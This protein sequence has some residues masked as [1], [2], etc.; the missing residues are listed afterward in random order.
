MRCP[1]A[2]ALEFTWLERCFCTDHEI[3]HNAGKLVFLGMSA[4]IRGLWRIGVEKLKLHNG[5]RVAIIGGGPA[6]AFFA[7][8]ALKLARQKGLQITVTIFDGKNFMR[9]GP[10]GCNMCAGVISETLL[11]RLDAQ[12]IRL[13]E[14]RVQRRIDGYSV[15]TADQSLLLTHP[16]GRL[17]AISTVYRGSGP[18]FSPQSTDVS[19]DDFLLNHA[20]SDGARVVEEVVRDIVLSS[21]A[22]QP[23]RLLCGGPDAQVA[24]EADLLVGAFGLNTTI[25]EKVVA[26]GFGYRPPRYVR[27]FQ[28][29]L[30]MKQDHIR[31]CLGNNIYAFSLGLGRI[32][33]AAITPKR[34]H[35]TV[36]V[37][38]FGDVDRSDLRELL[39]QPAVQSLLPQDDILAGR[40]CCC[41]PR[42]AIAPARKPFTDR[43]VIV[44]D[45]SCCRYYKNGI[46]SSFVTAKLAAET[47][48]NSGISAAAFRR[49]YYSRAK[50]AVIRD[51]V[52]GRLL[53]RVHDMASRH[54]ILTQTYYLVASSDRPGDSIAQLARQI[55]WDMFT[56][57]V[58]YRTV[59]VRSLDPRLQM[60]L[61]ITTMG[62]VA[63]RIWALLFGKRRGQ[64]Q[65]GK[66]PECKG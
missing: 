21:D 9:Q 54:R 58:S 40:Y 56:G 6:G 61:T 45:A 23:V 49:D 34:E 26:L 32:R 17:G 39:A 19:F 24:Y 20:K 2:V 35:V 16:Q 46:E 36:S 10:P 1:I 4:R 52:Y 63:Q 55:L 47:A 22:S 15:R 14:E 50:R 13:P 59:F 66:T 48:F 18:R 5:S 11:E 25:L 62:L 28:A 8:F 53:F 41:R 51:N 43:F 29:E 27:A 64:S 12:G 57:N 33:F 7:H 44:G 30:G 38:G 37:I 3:D 42:I 31:G 60:R 65:G